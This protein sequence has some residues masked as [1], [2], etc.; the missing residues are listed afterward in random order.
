MPDVL[1]K[2]LKHISDRAGFRMSK[3]FWLLEI[4]FMHRDHITYEQLLLF[5]SH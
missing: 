2:L 5:Q 4:Q 3:L 1:L